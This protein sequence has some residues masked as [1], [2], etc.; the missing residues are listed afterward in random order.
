[1]RRRHTVGTHLPMGSVP[2]CKQ[3]LESMDTQIINPVTGR[4][5][6]HRSGDERVVRFMGAWA[7]LDHF[8]VDVK[9]KGKVPLRDLLHN[10]AHRRQIGLGHAEKQAA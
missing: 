8:M 2:M 9:E 5:Y 10:R 6:N 1:M 7:C 4:P 3:C